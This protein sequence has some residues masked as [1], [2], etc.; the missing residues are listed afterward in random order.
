MCLINVR[1]VNKENADRP[2]YWKVMM[3][4]HSKKDVLVP[5]YSSQYMKI[6]EPYNAMYF[7]VP[8]NH[9]GRIHYHSCR[10]CGFHAFVCK[11]DAQRFFKFSETAYRDS[12]W[13]SLHLVGV[14]LGEITLEGDYVLGPEEPWGVCVVARLQTIREVCDAD[15]L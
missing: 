11:Q 14:E 5:L 4:H 2:L 12:T 13:L 6:G 9:I 15:G 8:L 10:G 3:E 1:D 7:D